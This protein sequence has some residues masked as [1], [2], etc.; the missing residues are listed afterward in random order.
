MV[1]KMEN[2]EL[3]LITEF[4]KTA[5]VI[6]GKMMRGFQ[7]SLEDLNLNQTMRRALLILYDKGETTMTEL[8][9]AIGLEKGSL[10]TVID[11]L[12]EKRLVERKRDVG[13]RRKVNILLTALGRKKVDILRMEIANYIKKSLDTLQARDRE[14]FYRAVKVLIDISG[15]L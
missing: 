11:Q 5:H 14:R 3:E 4:P 10:T 12:I 7:T 8:H 1:L 15:K 2:K 6:L 9:R 13:D